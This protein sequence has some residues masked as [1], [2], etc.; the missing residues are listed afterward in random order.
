MSPG[1]PEV[2]VRA[3]V[4]R[5]PSASRVRRLLSRAA[6]ATRS[7]PREVS[8]FFCGDRRMQG[9]NRRYRRRN[10]PTDVLAFPADAGA[11]ALLGDIVIS[12]PYATRQARKRGQ[13]VSEEVD[14]LLLHGYLHLL[15]YD[16]ETDDGKMDALEARLRRRLGLEE[17]RG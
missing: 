10:R 7:R 16:H 8:V 15:G 9:L 1:A 11:G 17:R 5:A 2:G 14:R 6:L 13:P 12:I 3:G 4:G